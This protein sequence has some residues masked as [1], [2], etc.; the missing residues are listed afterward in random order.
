MQIGSRATRGSDRAGAALQRRAAAPRP[1]RGTS[2]VAARRA[3]GAARVRAWLVQVREA[4]RGAGE[5]DAVRVL[6]AP[7]P[8]R[9]RGQARAG[10]RGRAGGA[11][12]R[13]LGVRAGAAG[14]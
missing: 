11:D 4:G 10:G 12:L 13:L 14:L 3:P 9:R 8:D 2:G 6:G 5:A 7:P 1:R